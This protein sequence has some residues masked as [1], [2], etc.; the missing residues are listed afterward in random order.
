MMFEFLMVMLYNS[1]MKTA[2]RLLY[3]HLSFVPL[4]L[5]ALV[6]ICLFAFVP[7]SQA[8]QASVNTGK[9]TLDTPIQLIVTLPSGDGEV[10]TS[11][12]ED[13]KVLSRGSSSSV[14]IINGQ[15]NTE[16]T[17]TY[18]LLPLREGRLTI[19]ALR[20]AFDGKTGYTE[21]IVIQVEKSTATEESTNENV[22][23]TGTVDEQTPYLGQ[24]IVY[25]FRLLYAVQ[26]TDLNYEAP[27][28]EGFSATQIGEQKTGQ[29]VIDSRRYNVV[30]LTYLLI[31]LKTGN[32]TIEPAQLQCNV[33][34]SS[35]RNGRSS[36]DS[37]F[38][39]SFFG[40]SQL[41]TKYY[42]SEPVTIDVLP[43]PAWSGSEPFS[44]LVGQFDMDAELEKDEASVG[45]SI[46]MAVTL[47]GNG[48][49]QDAEAPEL[50]IPDSFK[51]YADQPETDVQLNENGYSGTKVFRTAL[52]PIREGNYTLSVAPLVYFDPV[53]KSYRR[54]A[55]APLFL[56]A[57]ASD[58]P[59]EI[60]TIFSSRDEGNGT[61]D[62]Q[63]QKVAFTGRDILA[64]TTDL[65]AVKDRTA[66][67]TPWFLVLLLAPGG[68]FLITIFLLRVVKKDQ[69]PA[70]EMAR[71]SRLALKAAAESRED[72]GAGLLSGL[73][74]ALLY[75]VMARAGVYG[76]SLT[77]GE[78]ESLL[79]QSA[80]PAAIA[81][82]VT[83]LFSKL[84]SARFGKSQLSGEEQTLVAQTRKLVNDLIR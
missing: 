84:E 43:L 39:D 13:F 8:Q 46:T 20:V 6:P 7:S 70:A 55:P 23:I 10:D 4:C 54:L 41:E 62:L 72:D 50:V 1:L 53:E 30:S 75:A 68:V 44:G 12:I 63:K 3:R 11:V 15:V 9:T 56:T 31:P 29:Q 74:R 60:P 38:D 83:D 18:S 61:S 36:F 49:L 71:K 17:R 79:K 67:A 24:Q 28:F 27:S 2:R 14:R 78:V 40:R 47:Q 58:T 57:N 51:Q 37:F 32:I 33:V 59:S 77:A 22:R 35:R 21:P 48:N 19:P 82:A 25:T 81:D 64:I 5:C 34:A 42:R 69:G 73:Y 45:D 26:I 80:V 76:E 16:Q 65:D 66:M 52:V